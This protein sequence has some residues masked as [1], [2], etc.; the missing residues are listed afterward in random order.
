VTL[1]LIV[2]A[3]VLPAAAQA[4]AWSDIKYPALPDFPIPKP[5]VVDLPNGMKVFLLEDRELP[6]VSVT[7]L[8]RAGANWEP[9]DKTGL[10]FLTGSVQRTGGPR[11]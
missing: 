8:V 7:A 9:A 6:L 3:A 10:A 1:L 5:Q 2:A 4:R 11:R